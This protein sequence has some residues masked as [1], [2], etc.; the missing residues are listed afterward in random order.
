M[1]GVGGE[2]DFDIKERNILRVNILRD[3]LNRKI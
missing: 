2:F 1:F 3:I